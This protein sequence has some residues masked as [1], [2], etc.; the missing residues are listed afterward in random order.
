ME[1]EWDLICNL[2]VMR[3]I[4]RL[5]IANV[6]VFQDKSNTIMTPSNCCEVVMVQAAIMNFSILNRPL[7]SNLV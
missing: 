5:A 4:C 2:F 6:S 1:D 7:C 3:L